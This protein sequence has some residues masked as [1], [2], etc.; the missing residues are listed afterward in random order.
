M[1]E[2]DDTRFRRII[3]QAWIDPGFRAAL[4]RDPA[5]T[6]KSQGVVPPPGVTIEVIQSTP[7]KRYFVIP[8]MP[9]KALSAAEVAAKSQTSDYRALVHLLYNFHCC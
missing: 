2:T 3:E 6:L 7:T 1:T 5:G 9:D 8:P 4:A